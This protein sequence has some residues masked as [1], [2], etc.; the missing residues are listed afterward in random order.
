MKSPKK[1]SIQGNPI[2]KEKAY[3][4]LGDPATWETDAKHLME[5]FRKKPEHK[6]ESFFPEAIRL[7][8]L[9]HK[10][11]KYRDRNDI[12]LK[13]VS[14]EMLAIELLLYK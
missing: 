3:E 9:R 5:D 7:M 12:F 8:R 6:V 4:G 13:T 1:Q 14:E 11:D 10:L 2:T